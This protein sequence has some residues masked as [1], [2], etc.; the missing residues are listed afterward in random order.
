[1]GF[2]WLSEQIDIQYE[3]RT[4]WMDQMDGLNNN[5]EWVSKRVKT[6]ISIISFF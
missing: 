5:S 3:K 1:V 2:G 6:V 4:N